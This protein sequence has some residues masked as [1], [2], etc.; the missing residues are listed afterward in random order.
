MPQDPSAAPNLN[1]FEQPKKSGCIGMSFKVIAIGCVGA[2]VLCGGLGVV[3]FFVAMSVIK[4]SP[5]YTQSVA[6]A[7]SNLEVQKR[8]GTPL[9]EG[10]M[11]SGNVNSDSSTSGQT[12]NA[13]LS[14]PLSGP[15]GSG[16]IHVVGTIKNGAWD[17]SVMEL[18]VGTEH[19]NL[20]PESTA[21]AKPPEKF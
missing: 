12:G 1:Q 7:K 19:I 15:N 21:P 5:V 16:T 11:P 17:Y 18:D 2:V 14:I 4:S 3:G 13:D 8:L 6:A 20:L 9:K 10:Y